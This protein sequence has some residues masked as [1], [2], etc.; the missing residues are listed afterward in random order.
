[1]KQINGMTDWYLANIELNRTL[2]VFLH[3]IA[4]TLLNDSVIGADIG[5]GDNLQKIVY[6]GAPEY[7]LGM[8]MTILFESMCPL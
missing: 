8:S 3:T 5:D 2:S 1:M 7:Y 6:F 4:P